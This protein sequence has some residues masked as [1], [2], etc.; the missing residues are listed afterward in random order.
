MGGTVKKPEYK[1]IHKYPGWLATVITVIVGGVFIG[2]L[3]W[4]GTHGHDDH[5]EGHGEAHGE[6][7]GE[8]HKEGA[9]K[10]GGH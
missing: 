9:N 6:A 1:G 3:V 2:A 10:E 7:H 8:D 4:T 5:G